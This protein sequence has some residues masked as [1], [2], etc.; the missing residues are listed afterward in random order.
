MVTR[1]NAQD[2]SVIAD[3]RTV[4]SAIVTIALNGRSHQSGV[5]LVSDGEDPGLDPPLMSAMVTATCRT[6]ARH[7]QPGGDRDAMEPSWTSA[8]HWRRSLDARAG[9][10][11]HSPEGRPSDPPR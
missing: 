2:A 6:L 5:V 4:L 7:V 11:D 1:R 8:K 9:I 10:D 3:L